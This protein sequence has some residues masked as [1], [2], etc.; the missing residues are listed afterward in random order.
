MVYTA[1]QQREI[2]KKKPPEKLANER[3]RDRI[4][5]KIERESM[6]TPDR[7]T[8]IQKAIARRRNRVSTT[9]PFI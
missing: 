1:S 2:R 4:R 3:E 6:K 7:R 8:E 9:F 5:K